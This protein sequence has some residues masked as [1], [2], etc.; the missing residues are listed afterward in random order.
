[1]QKSGILTQSTGTKPRLRL[2][3]AITLG[4]SVAAIGMATAIAVAPS[5]P[6]TAEIKTVIEQLAVEKI[7]PVAQGDTGY[8]REERIQRGDTLGSILSRLGITDPGALDFISS[9]PQTRPMYQQLAPGKVVVARTSDDGQLQSL[10]FPLNGNE[11]ALIVEYERGQLVAHEKALRFESHIVMKSAEIHSSL[12]GATDASGIPDAIAT[13]LAEIF[14]GDMDFHR[15][16]RKGDRFAVVYEMQYLNGMPARSG[17]ILAAEFVNAGKTYRAVNFAQDGRS[18]YYTPDG[19][20]L[21]KAFLR[22]P[23]E[24][25]RVTSGFSMRFHPILQ[26]WRAHKGVDYGAPAGTKVRVTADGVISFAGQQGGYGNLV[27]VKHAGNYSTAYGHLKAFGKD[28]K[29]GKR[30]GQGDVVG[31]VGQT[32]WAT[33]PHLH[34]EF[35]VNNQQVNPLALSLPISVPLE[36]SQLKHF[37]AHAAPLLARLDLLQTMQLSVAD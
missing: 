19:K 1:M 23:L 5:D 25:S 36:A 13:Q 31:Y 9:S 33:G 11:T 7:Q 12:F 10:H 30:V 21:R 15:D 14:S 16:L 35:R 37:R 17:A 4:G 2:R 34:Y 8:L 6:D 27:V 28:I 29:T 18:N 26:Q 22:S 3:W 20:S 32:G 24:F